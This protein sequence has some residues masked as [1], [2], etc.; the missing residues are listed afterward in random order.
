MKKGK[1]LLGQL[2]NLIKSRKEA[3]EHD[4]HHHHHKTSIEHI[5]HGVESSSSSLLIHPISVK[6]ITQDSPQAPYINLDQAH[7]QKL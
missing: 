6:H 2:D 7:P 3:E 1:L 5:D 4:H